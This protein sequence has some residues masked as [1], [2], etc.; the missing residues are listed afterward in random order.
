MALFD[1][2]SL[3]TAAI[4]APLATKRDPLPPQ[5]TLALIKDIDFAQMD[6]KNG[7]RAGEKLN[8]MNVKVEFIDP[9]YIEL[10]KR[11]PA[12]PPVMVYDLIL[13]LD[14]TGNIKMG[15]NTNIQLGRLLAA[16]GCNEPGK[17]LTD[18]VGKVVMVEVI[19]VPDDKDPTIIYDRIGKVAPAQ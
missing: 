6:I 14:E 13:D 16:T 15:P 11:D 1:I 7:A 19:N 18:I 3:K 12:N 8:K 5:Q 2:K 4:S 9:V 10:A 17:S